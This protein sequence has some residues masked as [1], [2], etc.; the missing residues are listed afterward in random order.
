MVIIEMS[1]AVQDPLH[2]GIVRHY[3]FN[4]EVLFGIYHKVAPGCPSNKQLPLYLPQEIVVRSE[5]EL[6]I[7]VI[8]A[9]LL[10]FGGLME[11]ELLCVVG[12]L[13][14]HDACGSRLTDL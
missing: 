1:M 6:P 11:G 14:F 4:M 3:S 8:Q 12:A 9:E 13:D 10:V 2:E 5:S 7:V